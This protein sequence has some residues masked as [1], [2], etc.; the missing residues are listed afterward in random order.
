MLYILT[1]SKIKCKNTLFSGDLER[2][3][4]KFSDLRYFL[5][6]FASCS[7]KKCYICHMKLTNR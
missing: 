2:K 1:S 3:E 5:P 6:F 4:N 7:Q